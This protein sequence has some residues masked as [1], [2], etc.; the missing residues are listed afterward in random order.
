MKNM[1]FLVFITLGTLAVLSTLNIESS[2]KKNNSALSST[3]AKTEVA[4]RSRLLKNGFT[5]VVRVWPTEVYFGDPVYFCAYYENRSGAT[6]PQCG[7]YIFSRGPEDAYIAWNW[8]AWGFRLSDATATYRLFPELECEPAWI[9]LG[10]SRRDYLPNE[11]AEYI[12]GTLELPPL[13]DLRSEFWKSL[14]AAPEEGVECEL[15]SIYDDISFKIRVKPRPTGEAERLQRWYDATP[16]ALF[17]IVPSDRKLK[18][19]RDDK[20]L[21]SSGKSDIKLGFFKRYDPWLFVRVGN[22]KPSD[23]NN[24]TTVDGW[25]KLE[26][27]FAPSTLRDEITLTRLQLEYY[28]ADKGEASDA[29]L[30]T[31]VDWLSQRPEPQRVVL[32]QSLLSKRAKFKETPLEAKNAT[33][34]DALT[35]AF[36][37][38]TPTTDDAK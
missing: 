6:I 33:L 21:K 38:E 1:P 28:D 4:E 7:D 13:E 36:P 32:S 12:C 37:V 31:L 17:P 8:I 14:S 11:S 30:K 5:R 23:P 3:L 2:E 19:P 15:R 16:P 24:P 27:E 10:L 26:A 25:R 34:C 35:S 22:R 20:I 29:A 9:E 18:I